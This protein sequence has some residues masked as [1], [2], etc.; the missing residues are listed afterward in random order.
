MITVLLNQ[1]GLRGGQC[2][3]HGAVRCVCEGV[4]RALGV[5]RPVRV[6]LA[7]VSAPEI[8]RLNAKY[9]GKNK[10][11]DV[12]SF[13]LNEKDMLGELLICYPVAKRQAAELG[14]STRDE[15]LFL[16]VHGLLHLFGYDHEKSSD[17]KRMFPLQTKILTRLGID[18]RL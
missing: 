6:S 14:H 7:F 17:A 10:V 18:P 4:A 8:R 2:L 13:N 16:L 5:H 12:L 9:R 11:T 15:V 3:P 1:A